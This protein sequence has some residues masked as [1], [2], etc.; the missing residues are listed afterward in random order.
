M[1]SNHERSSY[2]MYISHQMISHNI[3]KE[4]SFKKDTFPQLQV[5]NYVDLLSN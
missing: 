2:E 3:S 5:N 4:A 1:K